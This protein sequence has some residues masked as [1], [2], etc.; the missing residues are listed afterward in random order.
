MFS[1]PAPMMFLSKINIIGAGMPKIVKWIDVQCT[2]CD[3]PMRRRESDMAR[4]K[5]GRVFCSLECR[6][7]VGSKPRRR[8][9]RDCEECGERFYPT[10]S[11]EQRFCSA[12]CLGKS[13]M[14][15]PE[16][17]SCVGCGETHFDPTDKYCSRQC[18]ESNRA[19]NPLDRY[20][21]GRPVIVDGG[22]YVR[23]YEPEHPNAFKSGRVLEHRWVMEQIVG[24]Y[25]ETDEHVH[26][27]DHVRTNNDPDNL[28]LLS[29][30]EH[31]SITAKENGDAIRDAIE[32]RQKLQE[33]ERRYGPL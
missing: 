29:A 17:R 24:R 18:Y 21:N 27:I 30:R 2:A 28:Q 26:H 20:H 8:S 10:R 12:K 31:W 6:H 1:A 22:G 16:G 13:Q 32:A 9:E 4:L 25:L 3:K 15:Y 19:T 14:R 11:A 23:I 5:T 33:Y 7:A